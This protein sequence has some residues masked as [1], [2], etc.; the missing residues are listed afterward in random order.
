MAAN[1]RSTKVGI[2]EATGIRAA[3]LVKGDIKAMESAAMPGSLHRDPAA[4][5]PP[6][7]STG[8]DA[9]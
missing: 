8:V 5:C 4:A 2:W 3:H 1:A 9:R 7:N 6:R